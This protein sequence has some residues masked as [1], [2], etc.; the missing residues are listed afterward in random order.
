MFER[1]VSNSMGKFGVLVILTYKDFLFLES[2]LDMKKTYLVLATQSDCEKVESFDIRNSNFYNEPNYIDYFKT[3][4]NYDFPNI[5]GKKYY[6]VL[7]VGVKISSIIN[8]D[9]LGLIGCSKVENI[10]DSQISFIY[11]D[12]YVENLKG[13]SVISNF[14]GLTNNKGDSVNISHLGDGAI[15]RTRNDVSH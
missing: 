2:N 7:F 8:S 13:N 4:S 15:I 10:I 14:Y 12:C 5:I 9:I 11:H 6:N 1:E 3:L